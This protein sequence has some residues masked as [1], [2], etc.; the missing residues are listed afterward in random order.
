MGL[1]GGHEVAGAPV[2]QE[3]DPLTEA[4]QRSGAELIG[5]RQT[6]RDVVGKSRA[7]IVYEE[8]GEKV[9][10]FVAERARRRRRR[11]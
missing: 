2:V 11:C 8:I 7:H 3:E 4:P 6:L 9:R 1:N 10:G 5:S